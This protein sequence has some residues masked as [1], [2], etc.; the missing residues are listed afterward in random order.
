ML[1]LTL[2]HTHNSDDSTAKKGGQ[3]EG[4]PHRRPRGEEANP[5]HRVPHHLQHQTS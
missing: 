4:A 3:Q 1:T 2:G 5:H